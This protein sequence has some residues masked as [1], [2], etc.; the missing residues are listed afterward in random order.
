MS[1]KD[2][3]DWRKIGV[4]LLPDPMPGVPL[5][6]ISVGRELS[7]ET[8]DLLRE[9]DQAANLWRTMPPT[10]IGGAVLYYKLVGG[11]LVAADPPVVAEV[12]NP[13]MGDTKPWARVAHSKQH[14]DGYSMRLSVQ[15]WDRKRKGVVIIGL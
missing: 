6:D 2:P 5:P 1:E 11:A 8:K 3:N 14:P 15:A 4:S 13:L 9:L 7:Q 12:P 10:L